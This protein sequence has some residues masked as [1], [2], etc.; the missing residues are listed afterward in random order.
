MMGLKESVYF[1]SWF[2]LFLTIN[3]VMGL[4]IIGLIGPGLFY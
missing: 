4:V 3:I 2:L 1:L